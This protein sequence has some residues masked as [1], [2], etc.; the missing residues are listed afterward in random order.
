MDDIEKHLSSLEGLFEQAT[1]DELRSNAQ[2]VTTDELITYIEKLKFAI[3]FN[4]NA[5]ELQQKKLK[6]WHAIKQIKSHT[7]VLIN[8]HNGTQETFSLAQASWDTRQAAREDL[9][10][11]PGEYLSYTLRSEPPKRDSSAKSA[12]RSTQ[13]KHEFSY[14]GGEYAFHFSTALK[15]SPLY[16]AFSFDTQ[17]VPKRELSTRSAGKRKLI[18]LTDLDEQMDKPPYSYAVTINLRT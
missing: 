7:S 8:I 1:I 11:A 13:I 10:I 5:I 4:S 18:C 17:Y 16:E 9:E 3:K 15:L 12:F 14:Q 6:A 2:N